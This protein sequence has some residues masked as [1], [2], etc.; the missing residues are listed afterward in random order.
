MTPQDADDEYEL[1]AWLEFCQSLKS[2]P[3]GAVFT[4][5]QC[6]TPAVEIASQDAVLVSINDKAKIVCQHQGTP[7]KPLETSP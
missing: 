1:A 5:P 3:R 7:F 6:A 2:T 4:L